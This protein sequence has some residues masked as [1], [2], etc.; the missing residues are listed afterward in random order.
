M[1]PILVVQE[2]C[3]YFLV[4][5]KQN[6]KREEMD[7]SENRILSPH[8]LTICSLYQSTEG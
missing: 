7:E 6:S 1:W 5:K 8:V 2:G 3:D 4:Q